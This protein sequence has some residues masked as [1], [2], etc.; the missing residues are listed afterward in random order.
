MTVER[1]CQNRRCR[2]K[3]TARSADVARG[4]AKFCSKSCK[5]AEQESRTHQ[6][7]IHAKKVRYEREF[8]GIAQ[9]NRR[10]EYVGFTTN[11]E[12]DQL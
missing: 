12:V 1:S 11:G 4:W 9:F 5:A 8:G 6:H 10:G 3:F 7:S 2:K